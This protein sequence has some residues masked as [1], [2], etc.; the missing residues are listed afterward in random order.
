MNSFF[1]IALY[2]NSYCSEMV[3]FRQ[4]EGCA[5]CVHTCVYVCVCVCPITLWCERRLAQS[6]GLWDNGVRQDSGTGSC[7]AS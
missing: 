3:Y 5:V 6:L 2:D 7:R 1:L 4:K